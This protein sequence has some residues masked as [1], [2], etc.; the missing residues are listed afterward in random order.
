M[1]NLYTVY[2]DETVPQTGTFYLR[3]ACRAI[4]KKDGL[5]L[6]IRS[7]RHGECKFPGGGLEGEES[8]ESCIAREVLEETGRK[9]INQPRE[10]GK[11]L[12]I[13]KD[14]KMSTDLFLHE[15]YY[16]CC[17][18]SDDFVK[19]TYDGYEIEFGYRPLWLTLE[20]AIEINMSVP[21]HPEI[22]WKTRDTIVMQRLKREE[23]QRAD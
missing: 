1:R 12:E 4:I 14:H 13:G 2:R 17:E 9:V 20:E 3:A 18:V 23:D 6:F 10:Y 11:V 8:H 7:Q 5:F 19:P 15:S 21:D 16:Y 22:P